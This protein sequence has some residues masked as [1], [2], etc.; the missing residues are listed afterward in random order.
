[1]SEEG[2]LTPWDRKG[3]SSSLKIGRYSIF[4][5]NNTNLVKR[6]SLRFRYRRIIAISTPTSCLQ[7]TV[8]PINIIININLFALT[9][10]YPSCYNALI[11]VGLL[12][13]ARGV[14]RNSET[15]N[16]LLNDWRMLDIDNTIA[17][18]SLSGH[19]LNEPAIAI[20]R[21][22]KNKL[23]IYSF[24]FPVHACNSTGTW[25]CADEYMLISWAHTAIYIYMY[26]HV[27]CLLGF[28]YV[29]SSDCCRYMFI[30]VSVMCMIFDI[31][32]I[33]VLFLQSLENWNKC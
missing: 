6:H 12:Q 5:Y 21:E 31:I 29:P 10:I 2:I 27:A 14:L 19:H 23:F 24:D 20:F 11:F 30:V 16:L 3:R 22:C 4:F 28:K 13:N 32:I 25:L 15:M 8:Q 17:H 18:A 1:M 9:Q 26:I 7:P 33:I